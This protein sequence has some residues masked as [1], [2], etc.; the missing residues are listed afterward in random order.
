[1]AGPPRIASY[2]RNTLSLGQNWHKNQCHNWRIAGLRLRLDGTG[3]Y[4]SLLM[5]G[6]GTGVPM[7][8][9]GLGGTGHFSPALITGTETV[10]CEAK[11]DSSPQSGTVCGLGR[12][13]VRPVGQRRVRL[14]IVLTHPETSVQGSDSK[15]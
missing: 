10:I 1:M 11:R 5:V 2:P 7:A 4:S 3:H 6:T 14:T 15:C 8:G 12:D 13:R 9:V